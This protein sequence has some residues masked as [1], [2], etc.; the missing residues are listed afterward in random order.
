VPELTADTERRS[1]QTLDLP[2]AEVVLY[3]TFFPAL[4]ADRLLR[5]IRDTTAW[6][7][8]SMKLYGKERDFPRLTAWYGDD[9]SSYIYSGIKNVPLPWTPTIL[10]VKRAVEPPSGVLFNSILLNR[11]V[12]RWSVSTS[13][14]R[15]A[16]SVIPTASE[17]TV[18]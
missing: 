17:A 4:V 2:E 15:M 3:P 9:G 12:I 7:Q 11:P 14:Q 6:R 5:E 18:M 10:E 16:L 8:E 13:S 1:P